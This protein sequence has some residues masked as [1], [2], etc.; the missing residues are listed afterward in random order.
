MRSHGEWCLPAATQVK[1]L[2]P[3]IIHIAKG[4]EFHF[5]EASTGSDAKGE[6]ESGMP[7][8]KS[9]AGKRTVYIGTWEIR[10]V[11]VGSRQ[12]AEKATSRYGVSEVGPTNIRGVAGAMPGGAEC[13]LEGVGGLTQ[14]GDIR[15]AIH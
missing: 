1:V 9:A 10:N 3:E 5:S 11:P 2:S 8:S 4:Q 15:H 6:S 7:G 13:S 14:R 12:G